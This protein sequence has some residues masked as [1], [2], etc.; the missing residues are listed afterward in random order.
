MG[1]L[2]WRN[3]Y[4]MGKS[5]ERCKTVTTYHFNEVEILFSQY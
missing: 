1:V 5:D 2:F 4:L 3:R